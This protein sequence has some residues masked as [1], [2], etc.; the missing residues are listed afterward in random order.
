MSKIPRYLVDP[1]NPQSIVQQ[2]EEIHR[3]AD[4]DIAFGYPNDP[5][6]ETSTI[7]AGMAD[8]NHNGTLENIVGSWAEVT[9][10]AF[11]AKV[12]VHHNLFRNWPDYVLPVSGEPNV[13]WLNFGMSHDGTQQTYWD[14]IRVPGSAGRPGASFPPTFTTMS[15]APFDTLALNW[16]SNVIEEQLFFQVQLPHTWKEGTDIKPHVHWTPEIN[17]GANEC[18]QWGL[19]YSWSNISG[20]F[21]ASTTIYSDG[22]DDT[23]ATSAGVTIVA[24]DHYLSAINKTAGGGAAVVDGTGKTLSSMLA[25]RLF[26]DVSD[27]GPGTDDYGD[28]AGLLELD[29]HYEIDSL[30]SENEYTKDASLTENA[31]PS[32]VYVEADSAS[33][34]ANSIPLRLRA[35]PGMEITGHPVTVTLFFIP[36]VKAPLE[37]SVP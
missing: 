20:S 7:A 12:D 27:T 16:F 2:M 21:G 11:D 4:G 32:V 29:F 8:V 24:S 31:A 10:T 26:R 15:V 22:T 34:T 23:T 3:V 5:V 18:V 6:D 37:T 30:G 1:D 25:C 13:R 14:D 33:L 35:G 36:A 28:E 9:F 19:E 17:A